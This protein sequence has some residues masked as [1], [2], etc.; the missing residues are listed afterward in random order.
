[1]SGMPRIYKLRSLTVSGSR[2]KAAGIIDRNPKSRDHNQ[3]DRLD[4]AANSPIKNLQIWT[5]KPDHEDSSCK[6]SL[7]CTSSGKFC[8]ILYGF[9]TRCTRKTKAKTSQ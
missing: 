3:S 5:A 2:M 6:A 1:M 8:A 4:Q 9:L 7:S